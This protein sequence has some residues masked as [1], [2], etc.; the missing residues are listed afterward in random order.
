MNLFTK[1]FGNTKENDVAAQLAEITIEPQTTASQN[2]Q[3]LKHL[4]QGKTITSLEALY[5]FNCLRLS[6]RIHDLRSFGFSIKTKNVIKNGK[7]I[8]EY[9]LLK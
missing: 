8:A 4:K 6:A 2:K 7:R 9:K 5:L 1:L 3:I